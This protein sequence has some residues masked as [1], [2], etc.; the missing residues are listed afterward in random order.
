M[1]ESEAIQTTVMQVTI[2]A[3]TAVVMMLREA[4]VRPTL[5]NSMANEGEAH[6]HR[7][8]RPAL[9]QPSFDWN[10]WD[11]DIE[12]LSFEIKV[13]NIPQNKAYELI[14]MKKSLQ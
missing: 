8:G 4:D 5:G 6:R 1:V 10:I 2:Q 13:M 3:A 14:M 7:H 9:I 12:L 11:K